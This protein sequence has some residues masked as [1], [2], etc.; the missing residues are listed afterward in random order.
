LELE[1]SDINSCLA[2]FARLPREERERSIHLINAYNDAIVESR[3]TKASE[4]RP[5]KQFSW[6]E[7]E[8]LVRDFRD[9]R[10]SNVGPA[11]ERYL[12]LLHRG[13]RLPN[14]D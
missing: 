13:Y 3:T 1:M 12:S 4:N 10:L 9:E 6:D 5:F 2:A 14:L 8:Q 7:V 11:M